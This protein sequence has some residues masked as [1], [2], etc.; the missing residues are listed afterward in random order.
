M[1]AATPPKPG[2]PVIAVPATRPRCSRHAIRRRSARRSRPWPTPSPGAPRP[3]PRCAAGWRGRRAEPP[4]PRRPRSGFGPLRPVWSGP[5]P[6]SAPSALRAYE[7]AL[8][9]KLL[10]ELGHLRLS[11]LTRPWVQDVVD[12]LLAE[13][14][15][16]STVRN[17]VLP[18]RAIYRRAV[19]RAEV[20]VNPTL[21]PAGRADRAEEPG[22]AAAGPAERDAAGRARP[23]S[24]QHRALGRSAHLRQDR[25][26]RVHGRGGEARPA[27]V[28]GGPGG[29]S[30]AP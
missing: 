2:R 15:S 10:P 22:R 25:R 29:I 13:G 6:E 18:L 12:R 21:G 17:A 28:A 9:G 20:F 11:S 4:W 27:S 14:R 5:A 1:P 26:G 24:P 19:A 7:Q 30:R 3:R 23:P 8:R 16:P